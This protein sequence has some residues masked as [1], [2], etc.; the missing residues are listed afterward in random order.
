[1]SVDILNITKQNFEQIV[2]KS[3]IPVVLIFLSKSY[4]SCKR[5]AQTVETLAT[6]YLG[7]I[8]FGVVD[9]DDQSELS[10]QLGIGGVP[11]M[12]VLCGGRLL[13]NI[14][15]ELPLAH[16]KKVIDKLLLNTKCKKAAK[17]H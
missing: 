12:L 13:S 10:G 14:G 5:M 16:Y 2:I 6:Q 8:I 15:G 9:V 3:S 11:C 1:M 7:S 17:K 4:Q